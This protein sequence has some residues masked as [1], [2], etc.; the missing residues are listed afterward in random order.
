MRLSV[1]EASKLFR[2]GQEHTEEACD[3]QIEF[4]CTLKKALCGVVNHHS[5]DEP[6]T[7]LDTRINTLIVLFIT[8]HNVQHPAV[9]I[10]KSLMAKL[11]ADDKP[12]Y[13]VQQHKPHKII[14]LWITLSTKYHT[15]LSRFSTAG[16]GSR[17]EEC[18][19]L[20]EFGLA[21]T[22]AVEA[23][24]VELATYQFNFTPRHKPSAAA[25]R[26]AEEIAELFRQF[27][28]FDTL[29]KNAI[30]QLLSDYAETLEPLVKFLTR[31]RRSKLKDTQKIDLIS[32]FSRQ[33]VS[34]SA[35]VPSD[36]PKPPEPPRL[37]QAP[38]LPEPPR[39][40]RTAKEARDA[41][42]KRRP[43]AL[44]DRRDTPAPSS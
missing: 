1:E 37:F 7:D 24:G 26:Y 23:S 20:V 17:S 15:M 12:R 19:M 31:L 3:R 25:S 10:I 40:F 22:P 33:Y 4:L 41:V 30:P 34:I 16:D 35:Y 42:M 28:S 18:S 21:S 36:Q 29:S 43:A 39:L 11:I 5:K 32:R 8:Q 6:N 14:D 9:L 44:E 2:N 38:K 27:N 13:R